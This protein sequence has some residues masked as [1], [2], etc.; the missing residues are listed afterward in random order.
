MI[1]L[2]LSELIAGISFLLDMEKL[3]GKRPFEIEMSP[4]EKAIKENQER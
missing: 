2:I 1:W 4:I 3:L